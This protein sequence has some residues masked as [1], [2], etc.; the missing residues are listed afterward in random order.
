[1]CTLMKTIRVIFTRDIHSGLSTFLRK[2]AFEYIAGKD[3]CNAG[4]Q[5]FLIF[6]HCLLP[7]QSKI[8]ENIDT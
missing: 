7:Y 2:T 4:G 5:Y 6:S 8:Q 1:M 3:K